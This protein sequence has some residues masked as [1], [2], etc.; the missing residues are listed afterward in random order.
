MVNQY[1]IE[2]REFEEQFTAVVFGEVTRDELPAFLDQVFPQAAAY[3]QK[4]GVGP[5]GPA[6]AR[7]TDAGDGRWEVE[8]GYPATTP[9][10]GQGDVE[11]SELPQ[12]TAAV[13]THVGPYDGL[14]AAH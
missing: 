2:T 8:A 9:V 11:P 5:D 14:G 6:I 3:L 7:Y 10:G 13:V 12:C 4:F 1:E